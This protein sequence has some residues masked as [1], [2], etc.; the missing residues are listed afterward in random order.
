MGIDRKKPD[1]LKRLAGPHAAT[2]ERAVV[3]LL[4]G[5]LPSGWQ[6]VPSSPHAVVAADK[7]RSVYYK[8]FLPRGPGEGV[9]S[10]LRGG[11][12]RRAR[13][14]ARV[15][16]AHGFATPAI[17]CW[18][19]GGTNEFMV[20]AGAPAEGFLDFLLRKFGQPLDKEQLRG[21][22]RLLAEVGALIGRLHRS[23]I[24]HGDLR[25]NN[26]LVQETAEG[27]RF[28]FIDNE[29]NRWFRRRI[30]FRLLVKNLVQI[31]FILNNYVNR[32]DLLR[33]YRAYVAEYRRF[34]GGKA[35]W[36]VAYLHRKNRERLLKKMK[37]A[38]M[39]EAQA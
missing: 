5:R 38:G 1:S 6:W 2:Y 8:E 28:Y 24:V 26:L 18:G 37:K 31:S 23:G 15:L 7:A 20:T 32:T 33:L 25:A 11:R 34:T 35:R 22:R 16:L 14:Q 3:S 29:R 27:L 30:P 10:L 9:K 13:K 39:P 17:L 4:E 36:F 19:R 12:G 21:K